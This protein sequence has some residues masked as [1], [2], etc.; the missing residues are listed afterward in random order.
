M[1]ILMTKYSGAILGPIALVLGFVLSGIYD[2]IKLIT[3][4]HVEN[5]GISI[6]I[7]TIIIYSCLYPLTYKQQKF[8]RLSQ[9]MAPEL[10]E[11]KKK[12]EGKRDQESMTKMQMETQAVYQKYG[13]SA[14]GS[15]LQFI[16]QMPI[17]FALYRVFYNVPAYVTS[18]KNIF[19]KPEGT[20]IT[21]QIMNTPGWQDKM[22]SLVAGFKNLKTLGTDFFVADPATFLGQVTPSVERQQNFIVD[23]LYKLPNEGWEALTSSAYF[24]N[25]TNAD[26]VHQAVNHVNNFL[27]L[28]ISYTPWDYISAWFHAVKDHTGAAALFGFAFLA[29]LIPV[30]SY[31]SQLLS[32]KVMPQANTTGNE[33]MAAQMKSMNLLMPLMSL[34]I[35]FTVPVGLGVYWIGS[36]L[37]RTVQTLIINK[38]LDKINLEDIIEK[39]KEKA[40]KKR[41]KMGIYENQIRSNAQ[42]RTKSNI[43]FKSL[44]TDEEK[45]KQLSEANEIKAKARTDSMAYRANLVKEFNERN[46]KS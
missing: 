28:N 26:A 11:V 37:V 17:L 24:P 6:I 12:Y 43:Q 20:S 31:L 2:F 40:K 21:D 7:L 5:V 25:L 10:S 1:N 16:I 3:G 39:N 46:N 44:L 33:Q 23:V 13:V 32:I 36:A 45:E 42:L 18:V 19:I 35:C 4:G 30:C 41:E 34:V 27:G 14:T 8:S 29:L 38:R 15:C 22:T 9:K